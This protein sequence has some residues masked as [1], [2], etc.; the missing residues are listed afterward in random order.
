MSLVGDQQPIPLDGRHRRRVENTDAVVDAVL[1][2]FDEMGDLPT[3]AQVAERSGISP[4]S[5]FRYFEDVDA[6]TRAA[7]ERRFREA[8]TIGMLAPPI[9]ADL[10]GRVRLLLITRCRLF[11]YMGETAR[12]ARVLARQNDHSRNLRLRQVAEVFSPELSGRDDRNDVLAAVDVLCSFESW[13]VLRHDQGKSETEFMA[14]ISSALLAL[15]R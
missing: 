15:L 10:S 8:A 3:V 9:P 5:V 4:R 2:L 1:E 14:I 6:M 12:L 11:E 7:I 13:D